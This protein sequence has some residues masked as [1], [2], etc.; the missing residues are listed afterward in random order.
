MYEAH[1]ALL[2][3]AEGRMLS[4]PDRRRVTPEHWF[5]PAADMRALFADLPEACDNTLAIARRCAVMAETR[6]P[7]LP[8]CPKVRPGAT[9][10][11]TVRAMAMEGL[12][13]R[14]DAIGADAATRAIYRT[15]LDY[16]LGVI[17]KMG[18]SGYF[19]I[20]A[21]FI[22]WSK[23]QG[24]PVGPGRGSGA[25]SVAAWALTITDL[26][27]LRFNL[28]FERFLNPERVS[29]PDFDI[30]FCQEGRDRVIDYVRNEYG[31]DRV[32]QIITFGKLQ[33]RAA[34]RD[35]GRVLGLPFGQVNKVAELIPN[36]PA[37]P[38]TL[39]QAIDGEPRLQAVARRGRRHRPAAGNRAADRGPVSPRLH[40]RRRRRHRRPPADRA[41]P[42]LSRSE[43]R[44]PGHAIF[45]EARRA[46]RTGEIR[47]PRPDHADHPA[48]RRGF[49]A[50][51]G[52]RRSIWN[53]LPLDD[54]KTY[55]MLQRGDAGG[56]FQ[57]EGQGMRD[58][59]RQMRPDRFED[60][61]AAVALYRPGPMAN[62]PDYCRRKH[63]ETWEAPHPII[64]DI[65]AE[66]YGI[67]VYQEQVMQIA[68]KMAGYS[69]GGADLLRR[70]MGK[71]IAAEMEAQRDDLHRRRDQQRHRPGEGHRSLRPDGEVRRLRLQQ[72]A[73]RR[74]RAGRLPDRLAEG[75][76]PGSVPRRLH[77]PGA[78]QHR[79]PGGAEAGGGT[80]RHQDPAARH[81]PFRRRF[82]ASNAWRTAAWRSVTPWPR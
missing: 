21:D 38:V 58:M 36:N 39:Q 18:F 2:C 10:E 72:I 26:D 31:G 80:Q 35:V 73:R 75:E 20:V 43:I 67:I 49:P 62:I 79:P 65:L 63:G 53:G 41:G 45:D 24:I 81:Q 17:A 61:I 69:L 56:V 27:P 16:E 76:P 71:K 28:L 4:E 9:E 30:D 29:M 19:L 13:R 51:A 1:D 40:P 32:A 34:V 47:L 54:Q 50:R 37:K 60:L 64:H 48:A 15:R 66:T 68:Q 25:G 77:E 52:H 6:K 3:I 59:L 8:V 42:A 14:M 5:K 55:E 11:E 74:L 44:L 70:A 33:A 78:Q 46:G 57:L 12:E 7:L 22:Q 23:A 82:L